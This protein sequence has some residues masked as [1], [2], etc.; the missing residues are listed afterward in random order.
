VRASGH[1]TP[2]EQVKSEMARAG[3]RLVQ[4]AGFLEKQSFLVFAR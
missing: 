4:E 2:P 1:Y 3:Y